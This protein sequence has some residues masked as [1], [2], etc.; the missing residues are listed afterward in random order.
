MDK[1]FE[2]QFEREKYFPKICK[3]DTILGSAWT[4]WRNIH[5]IG[6]TQLPVLVLHHTALQSSI[7]PRYSAPSHRV[8]VLYH[9][10]LQCSITPRCSAPSHRVTV[11]HHTALQCSIT[12]RCSLPSHRVAVLHHTAL[13]CSITP[14]YGLQGNTLCFL[15]F[16][17]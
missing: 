4:E 5:L 3:S 1:M 10:A 14:R 12:P 17:E 9:T 7:T 16:I 2:W 13:Q 8:A 15:V 11:L 6:V